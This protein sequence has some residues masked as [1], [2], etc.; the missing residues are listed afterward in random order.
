MT[1]PTLPL[2]PT[3]EVIGWFE[4]GTPAWHAARANGIGGS[5]ISAVLGISP[6]ESYFSLWH[7]KKGLV[8][9][10]A[11]NDQMRWGKR[12]EAPIVDEFTE[13]HPDLRVLPAPTFHGTDRPWQIVNPDRLVIT[14]SGD[15]EVL[16][17]KTSRDAEGWGEEDTDQV[18]VYYKA[19]VR[20][21]LDALGLHRARIIVLI[22][23][24]DYREYVV[25]HDDV[26]AAIMRTRAAEFMRA[27]AADVRPDIDGHTATYQVVKD[28]VEGVEDVDVQVHADLRD[29]Y[30]AALDT[31]KAAEWEK[32]EASALVLDAIGT[33]RRA[34]V[35]L[36]KV[37]TRT[38]REGKTYSLQPAR[39][40]EIAA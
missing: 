23:G 26:D 39:N 4:P 19:Q 3:G 1:A 12:L 22:S 33:G 9:P 28:V 40:R 2:T 11:E 34:V 20:W 6:Y 17:V 5:E 13:L 8:S 18:P 35:G 36:D 37:A 10:V 27:L 7:R 25:E 29:R 21:Y 32:R 38:V 24:S 15:V 31:F 16:E 30:F 14:S